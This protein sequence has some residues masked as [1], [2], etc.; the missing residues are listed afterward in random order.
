V[1]FTSLS[2]GRSA[3]DLVAL[4]NEYF[5]EV[6]KE[7]VGH[8][9]TLDKFAGDSVMCFFGA[10][11]PQPDHRARALKAAVGH[12]KVIDALRQRWVG[13]GRPPIDCRIGLNTGEVVVGNIGSSGGQDYTVIGDAVNLASRLE[14]AN[15]EYGTRLMVSESVLAGA[16]GVVETRELD[17]LRVKGKKEAVR[18]L[19]VMGLAGEVPDERL[20]LRDLFVAALERYR[21]GAFQEALTGFRRCLEVNPKDGPARTFEKRCLVYL[22]TPPESVWDGVWEMKSK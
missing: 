19:E 10:P 22:E 5:D 14:G 2:E 20:R 17:R 13:M 12:L 15:K 18:V 7:I 11:L 4:L 21:S 8:E 1:G 16:E 9:G 3:H 6:G